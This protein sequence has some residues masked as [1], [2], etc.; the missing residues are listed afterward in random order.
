L[1]F[2]TAY[3][4]IEA[5]NATKEFMAKCH[6]EE[7]VSDV[8]VRVGGEVEASVEAAQVLDGLR[9]DVVEVHQVAR[10]V[11]QRKEQSSIG[12]QLK[13]IQK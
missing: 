8:V 6:L 1:Q 7:P 11:Q 5:I 12:A 2:E 3:F 13:S 9:R 4:K 10:R